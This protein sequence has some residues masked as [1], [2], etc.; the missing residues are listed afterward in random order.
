MD[1]ARV[2]DQLVGNSQL[3]PR[4]SRMHLHAGRNRPEQPSGEYGDVGARSR[5]SVHLLPRGIADSRCSQ[6]VGETVEHA[7]SI[8]LPA[9]SFPSL[10]SLSLVL[11]ISYYRW[12]SV[13]VRVPGP[14]KSAPD[15]VL[16]PARPGEPDR[17]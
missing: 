2:A 9:H 8:V 6:L 3:P 10:E 15:L 17:L 1:G 7:H 4:Q 5:Q 14:P 13:T 11:V 16:L 12:R